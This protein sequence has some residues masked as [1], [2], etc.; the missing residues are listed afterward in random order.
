MGSG[1]ASVRGKLIGRMVGYGQIALR[2]HEELQ[3]LCVAQSPG[4]KSR[5]IVFREIGSK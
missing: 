5:E 3:N 1:I 4:A 2:I